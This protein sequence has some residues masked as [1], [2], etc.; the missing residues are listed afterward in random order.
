MLLPPRATMPIIHDTIDVLICRRHAT[1][2]RDDS[3]HTPHDEALILY[4][5]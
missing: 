3:L 4:W 5:Y 1:R 2:E